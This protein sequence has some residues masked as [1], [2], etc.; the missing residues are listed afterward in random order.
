MGW[1][2]FIG[3]RWKIISGNCKECKEEIWV[4]DLGGEVVCVRMWF[5]DGIE[6]VSYYEE[7]RGKVELGWRMEIV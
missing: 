2:I 3:I 7:E 1:F 4:L 5:R 6:I